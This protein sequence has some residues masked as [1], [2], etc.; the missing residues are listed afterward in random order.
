MLPAILICAT[1][2]LPYE[3]LASS[4]EGEL[5]LRSAASLTL[6]LLVSRMICAPAFIIICLCEIVAL[7]YNFG[8]V[9]G[10]FLT[11]PQDGV[12]YGAT[13][14]ALFLIQL[15]A[16]LIGPRHERRSIG[17]DNHSGS[18]SSDSGPDYQSMGESA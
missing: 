8:A 6:I 7:T 9:V 5:A 15:T 4:F 3:M 16:A 11:E 17:R 10:Y 2:L 14:T 12:W 18:H 13:M 1:A